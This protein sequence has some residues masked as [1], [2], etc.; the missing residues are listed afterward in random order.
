MVSTVIQYVIQFFRCFFF[1]IRAM[2]RAFDEKSKLPEEDHCWEG[3]SV[4]VMY[5][6]PLQ[7]N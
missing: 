4:E 6:K 3:H 1:T 7:N 5:C 2:V